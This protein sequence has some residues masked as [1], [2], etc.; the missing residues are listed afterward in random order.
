MFTF[1]GDTPMMDP[2]ESTVASAGFELLHVTG[3][4][5]TT[6]AFASVTD[7]KSATVDRTDTCAVAGDTETQC[8][9][10]GA[11]ETLTSAYALC[12][13]DV[14]KIFADPSTCAVT[15]PVLVTVAIDESLVLHASGWPERSRPDASCI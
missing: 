8:G 11:F 4:S 6:C 3:T 2:V 14:T 5:G 7:A 13:P 15:T 12:V 10:G 1:P 9:T